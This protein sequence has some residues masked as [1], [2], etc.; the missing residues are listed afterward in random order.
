MYSCDDIR[1]RLSEYVDDVLS[2]EEKKD[3][4]KHLKSCQACRAELDALKCLIKE[5]K[6]LPFQKLP[7]G[8]EKQLKRRLLSEGKPKRYRF[9]MGNW[10]AYSS[11][12]AAAILVILLRT[13]YYNVFLNSDTAYVNDTSLVITEDSPDEGVKAKKEEEAAKSLADK[14]KEPDLHTPTPTQSQK[15]NK[16]SSRAANTNNTAASNIQSRQE[17]TNQIPSASPD[18]PADSPTEKTKEHYES[19][20]DA[21]IEPTEDSAPNMARAFSVEDTADTTINA[22]TQEDDSVMGAMAEPPVRGGASPKNYETDNNADVKISASEIM[23]SADTGY[24]FAAT[25]D[26]EQ[27][28]YVS[29]R[30]EV[31]DFD[32]VAENLSAKYNKSVQ[33]GQLILDLD[34]DDFNYVMNYLVSFGATVTQ[35]DASG[36]LTLNKCTIVEKE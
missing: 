7:E 33:Y 26:H 18:F 10:K 9:L 34:H 32:T 2:P 36:D 25:H 1:E 29:V 11:I 8:F 15:P 35:D 22:L 12:A 24:S 19:Q 20:E 31:E 27:P 6:Q 23:P 28:E 14:R 13:G 17:E 21:P 5:I 3:F 4:E 16:A 30:V